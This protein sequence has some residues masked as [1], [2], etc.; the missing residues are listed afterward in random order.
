MKGCHYSKIVVR[1]GEFY[2][3]PYRVYPEGDYA[4]LDMVTFDAKTPGQRRD[5]HRQ[6]DAQDMLDTR[7]KLKRAGL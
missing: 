1:D 4:S 5:W 3:G 7:L 2:C 6:H